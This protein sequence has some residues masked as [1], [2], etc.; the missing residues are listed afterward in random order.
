LDKDSGALY[1]GARLEQI[2][3]WIESFP[4]PLSLEEQAFLDTSQAA[5][6]EEAEKQRRLDRAKRLQ[7][8]L[9]GITAVLLLT[10]VGVAIYVASNPARAAQQI[11]A[12]A[13][14]TPCLPLPMDGDFNIA[15]A[16]IVVLAPDG[17]VNYDNR[18]GRQLTGRVY[19]DLSQ[20]FA[21]DS[22]VQIWQ[23]TLELRQ[24]RCLTIGLAADDLAEVGAPAPTADFV[25]A[26]VL[27]YGTLQPVDG[28][29][30][31]LVKFY[32]APQL[33]LDFS[34]LVG[35][36]AFETAVPV[37]DI[38][39]PGSEVD[40]VLGM[41]VEALAR[42]ARGFTNELLGRP[43]QALA[44]F[45]LAAELAPESDFAHFFV[46]QEY[47]FLAQTDTEQVE[48]YETAAF[49]AFSR[50]PDNARAKI[51]LG[52]VLFIR[53]QRRLNEAL[54]DDFSGDLEAEL[55]GLAA[56][57]DLA[58]AA[59][60]QVIE[61]GS[62]VEQYGVPVDQIARVGKGISLRL[63]GEIA[64]YQGD[65]EQALELL[66]TAV[67]T[68]QVAETTLAA[69]ND[70]RLLAQTYQAL[71]SVYEWQRFLLREEGDEGPSLAAF[72]LARDYYG[73]C[74]QLGEEFPFD[75]YMVTEIVEKLCRPSYEA[76]ADS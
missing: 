67:Q 63:K 14:I 30:E 65:S 51:G 1:R 52:G 54:D 9:I 59:F 21:G 23:D 60:L 56:E 76:S 26:D 25:N 11:E 57:A 42:I 35:T 12:G 66:E 70:Y 32:L 28:R 50:A 44:D 58:L 74:L 40:A 22:G 75:T 34:N 31:L 68:L 7:T 20:A 8:I 39:D 37:F 4:D 18:A 16:E 48:A 24:Q 49:D 64:Y 69:V 61:G 55:V 33:G 72:Q 2:Q 71:G 47:L 6:A 15:L 53:A 13:T 29:A 19:D 5:V 36:Y 10:I 73:Q 27:V 43:E 46:G 17:Q 45:E 62:Q 3:G 41:Q 38:D